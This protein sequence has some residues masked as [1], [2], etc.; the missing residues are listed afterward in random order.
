MK[1]AVKK[2][3]VAQYF[4]D[5]WAGIYTTYAGMKITIEYFFGKKVTVRY[6][7][8]RPVIPPG[9]RGLHVYDETKCTGC[10]ICAK[11]CPVDC[12]AIETQGRGKDVLLLR[13]D[14]N[15]AR[16]LFC[17]LCAEACPMGAL[18][19]SEHFNMACGTREDCVLHAARPKAPAEIEEHK[20]LLARKEA[21]RKEAMAKK[22]AERKAR[23]AEEAA[24]KAQEQPEQ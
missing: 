11:V 9:H 19:L 3:P 20:A 18:R 13:F 14:V 17:N 21:E 16:C 23:E 24:R 12:I 2:N 22:E 4:A 7:E 8:E 1:P 15:C 5:I 10:G 6:P